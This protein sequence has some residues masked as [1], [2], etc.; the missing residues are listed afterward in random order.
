MGK[1]FLKGLEGG[2]YGC[3]TPPPPVT[4]GGSSSS[5]P[6]I[7]L[8]LFLEGDKQLS[9][10]REKSCGPEEEGAQRGR[11][12]RRGA[13]KLVAKRCDYIREKALKD[14]CPITNVLFE[15]IL[16]VFLLPRTHVWPHRT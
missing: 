1:H 12:N 9:R 4:Y 15:G 2:K 14:K 10:S 5:L 6:T 3:N 7:V 13:H 11:Y 8:V 16:A